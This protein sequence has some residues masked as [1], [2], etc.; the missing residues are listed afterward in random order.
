MLNAWFG[1]T[2]KIADDHYL[3]T[4]EDDFKEV[5]VSVIPSRGIQDP[6]EK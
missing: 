6:L 2:K 1:H 5:I 3:N 4:T